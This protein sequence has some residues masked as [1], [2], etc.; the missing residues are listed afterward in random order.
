M[1][2]IILPYRNRDLK[3]VEFSLNSLQQ[4]TN[5]NFRIFFIDYGSF[6]DH[7]AKIES[8]C[9]SYSFVDY[10]FH[11]VADQLWNKSR[12]L[13][14]KIKELDAAEYCFIADAD[15]IFH[16][17]FIQKACQLQEKDKAVYFQVGFLNPK[18]D[19]SDINFKTFRN[20]RKSTY[21][22]TGLSMFPVSLLNEINGFDEF[23]HF[24]GAED[25]DIH[26]RLKNA[27]KKVDFFSEKILMLHQWHPSY[28]SAESSKLTA[29]L[30]VK[31]I[32]KLNSQ[33][34]KSAIQNKNTR[35]N[36]SGWGTIMS[37]EE[38]KSLETQETNLFLENNK[39]QIDELVYGQLPNISDRILK[40][41]V[42][43]TARGILLKNRLKQ[44][45]KTSHSSFYKM[46][47]VNDLL[48][49]HII[50]CYRNYPYY[51]K[52]LNSGTEIEFAINF[53]EKHS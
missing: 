29:T 48:L 20:Y 5:K 40:V 37:A 38:L 23:Y 50:S 26:V 4:Q 32:V 31:D 34:L 2:N 12:A 46:K 44:I 45:L 35:V 13:N 24:W 14:S 30:Q 27:G 15:L 28:R 8:L 3:R 47:E 17:E 6:P 52:V 33:H 19:L 39:I 7:A 42:K 51:Y 53:N 1:L 21:E 11:P 49:L 25:T 43:Q 18:E 16:P 9:D 10:K 41:R 36:F 22:A